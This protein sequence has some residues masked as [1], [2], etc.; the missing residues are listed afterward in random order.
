M[1]DLTKKAYQS[2]FVVVNSMEVVDVMAASNTVFSDGDYNV[3]PGN[4]WDSVWE[5][6]D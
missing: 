1:K 5:V 3:N 2:P 4:S 6:M